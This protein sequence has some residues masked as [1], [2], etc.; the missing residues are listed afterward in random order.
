MAL[1]GKITVVCA[2]VL[3]LVVSC[4]KVSVID[5]AG[6]QEIPA[7]GVPVR[8]GYV[9]LFLEEGTKTAMEG[10]AVKWSEG[11][12]IVVNSEAADVL[13]DGER[14]YVDVPAAANYKA[15]YPASSWSADG[16]TIP[17]AQYYA[18]SSFGN[19]ASPMYAEAAAECLIFRHLFGALCLR[20]TGTGN[21]V[22]VN[23]KDNASGAVCG[24]F[25]LEGNDLVPGTGAYSDVTL[26]C[27]NASTGAG[28][29]LSAEGTDF[30]VCIPA[31]EYS[32]G[33][34][35]T[36]SA[37]DGHAMVLE[38]ATP[39]TI[40]AGSLLETPAIAYSYSEDQIFSW[41]FDNMTMEQGNVLYST[42]WNETGKFTAPAEFI[43]S[44]NLQSFNLLCNVR[45]QRGCLGCGISGDKRGLLRL[46]RFSNLP[47]GKVCKAELSFRMR[48]D[49]ESTDAIQVYPQWEGT[50]MI[51]GYW[52]DGVEVN[53]RKSE[54]YNTRWVSGDGKT[55]LSLS[56]FSNEN[57]L[58]KKADFGGDSQ[59][60]DVKILLGAVSSNTWVN[61]QSVVV[62]STTS[63]F[64]IDDIEA[65]FI[66]YPSF[67]GMLKPGI[68]INPANSTAMNKLAKQYRR[69]GME[70]VDLFI[71]ESRIITDLEMD[72]AKWLEDFT[73]MAA[74]LDAMGVK[75]WG[76]HLPY[77]DEKF[78]ISLRDGEG[79]ETAVANMAALMEAMAPFKAKC[80]VAH[81]SSIPSKSFS[82]F[83]SYVVKSCKTLVEK[84]TSLGTVFCLENLPWT[85]KD[86]LCEKASN[87]KYF[88]DECPGLKIC[89]DTSHALVGGE[90]NSPE[91]LAE[92]L[93]EAVVAL[94]IH[95]GDKNGD[96]HLLPGYSGP[97]N[98]GTR[99][100]AINWKAFYTA[101]IDVC[102]YD[103]PLMYEPYAYDCYD[104]IVSYN[105]IADN[106]YG[107]LYPAINN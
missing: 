74:Q 58:I 13:F 8:E 32:S 76:I 9:R 75:V 59:W 65:R 63:D 94:H 29:P 2:A 66:D 79:R 37:D 60:H 42:I 50:G 6:E 87:L 45:E 28:V 19:G 54:T 15:F 34:T 71:S 102:H 68:M 85:N 100:D 39:R 95:G 61:F 36:V 106:C 88:V 62:S 20:I 46:P 72:P 99:T 1:R 7:A 38:S 92:T 57:M 84:A 18:E 107:Y 24:G 93:G 17:S 91:I 98:G 22:S 31:R 49:E 96:I 43:N 4:S 97:V 101:L 73:A 14:A 12:R 21:V 86:C 56:N 78:D 11:D 25:S 40:T 16:I 33:L 52:V 89:L 47:E 53:I 51:L 69:L 44:R 35:V 77:S 30:I 10:L 105:S 27:V 26:N 3:G 90:D 81:P 83:K 48:F 82:I 5:G 80:M 41:H 103:G 70:Y 64:Y 55:S 104:M 23:V 67:P